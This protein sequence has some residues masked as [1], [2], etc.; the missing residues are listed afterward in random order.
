MMKVEWN[1]SL[2]SGDA[3]IDKQHKELFKHINEF[4]DSINKEYNHEMT[5]RTLNFL[6]KYVKFHFE[7]EEQQM[8]DRCYPETKLHQSAHRKIVDSLV[9]C[10]KRLISEG[11]ATSV[12]E[13]LTTLLQV[14]FVEHIMQYDMRLVSFLREN[15]A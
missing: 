13:E 1:E 15:E 6:V 2:A 7:H 12:E 8:A 4:F 3:I 10:Y 9:H 11:N 14:W 5:V